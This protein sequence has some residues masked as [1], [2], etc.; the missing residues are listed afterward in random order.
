MGGGNEGIPISKFTAQSFFLIE[1]AIVYQ[2]Y[3]NCIKS[4]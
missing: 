2:V 4:E 3:N 1:V